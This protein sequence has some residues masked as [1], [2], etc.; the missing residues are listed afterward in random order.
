[1]KTEK[2]SKKSTILFKAYS[3]R[4]T[5]TQQILLK[6]GNLYLFVDG[7]MKSKTFKNKRK[8]VSVGR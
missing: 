5:I 3:S 8:I 1:M 6:K 4:T 7:M 2:K